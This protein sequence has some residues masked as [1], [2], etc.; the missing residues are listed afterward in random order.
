MNR[1]S[2]LRLLADHIAERRGTEV[3]WWRNLAESATVA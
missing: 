1:S 3:A 2:F